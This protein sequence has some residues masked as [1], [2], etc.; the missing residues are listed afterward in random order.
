MIVFSQFMT[1]ELR[2][3]FEDP[4]LQRNL[5]PYVIA[6]VRCAFAD[7][8]DSDIQLVTIS[9]GD[10]E[11]PLQTGTFTREDDDV[12][13]LVSATDLIKGYKDI[14]DSVLAQATRQAAYL[15]DEGMRPRGLDYE[16]VQEAEETQ[17][18]GAAE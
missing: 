10:P 6:A 14:S 4:V 13:D 8:L 5:P 9:W 12:D 11:K 1:P 3:D 15:I 7:S 2:C 18:R 17:E 16:T